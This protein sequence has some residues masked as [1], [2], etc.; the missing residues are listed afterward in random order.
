[1]FLLLFWI[2]WAPATVVVTATIFTSDNPVFCIIW[3]IF[4]WTGTIGIPIAFLH[5][6][7]VEWIEISPSE[8]RYGS[9]GFWRRNPKSFALADVEQ[10][11]FGWKYAG[12]QESPAA[13]SIVRKPDKWYQQRRYFFGYWLARD[14]K[15]QLFAVI[16]EFVRRNQVPL[17]TVLH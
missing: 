4:G 1:M 9:I 2:I 15:E 8:I 17:K 7:S 16:E 13:L 14:L 6:R 10:L 3:C 11:A 5:R 12:E